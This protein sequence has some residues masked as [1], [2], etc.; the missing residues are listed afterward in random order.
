M[1]KAS[2]RQ[3]NVPWP[4]KAHSQ[5][6]SPAASRLVD[7][8]S[9]GTASPRSL[10]LNKPLRDLQKEDPK[11]FGYFVEGASLLAVD[12]AYLCRTQG[13]DIVNTF[14]DFCANGRN[15]FQLLSSPEQQRPPLDR[16]S[17]SATAK[18]DRPRGKPAGSANLGVYSHG[19]AHHSLSGYEGLDIL[20]P[21]RLPSS[22]RLV[23][24]LRSFLINEISG[25]EWDFL[26]DKEWDEERAD[27]MPVL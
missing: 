23:D 5:T 20:S 15:L 27:E 11:A 25:A 9:G 17:S 13:L 4:Y 18:T 2:Y 21:W 8:Q 16:H 10:H 1:E 26:S 3:K 14:D 24:K 12:V 19:S 7:Q 6:S 22:S